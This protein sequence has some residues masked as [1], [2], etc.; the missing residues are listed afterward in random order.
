MTAD[1]KKFIRLLCNTKN[2]ITVSCVNVA[3]QVESECGALSVAL[4]VHLCFFS[5]E[6][7]NI[8]NNILDVRSMY[9]NCMQ[10]NSLSYFKMSRRDVYDQ[11]SL[12]TLKI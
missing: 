5:P 7:N 1:G 8:Y 2:E 4:A 3:E 12:F 10:Q 9:L 11:K 6:E